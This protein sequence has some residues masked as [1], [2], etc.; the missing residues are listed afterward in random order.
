MVCY[1]M[2]TGLTPFGRDADSEDDVFRD[3]L[4]AKI[5]FPFG[6]RGKSKEF[7]EALLVRNPKKRL[8]CYPRPESDIKEHAYFK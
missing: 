3:I 6:V 7:L 1:E 8:G 5:R 2:M 4:S